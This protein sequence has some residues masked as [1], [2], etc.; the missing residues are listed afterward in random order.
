M[1]K[2]GW[3][4]SI[5]TLSLGVIIEIPGNIAIVGVLACILPTPDDAD[6]QAAGLRSS[7]SSSSTR[8]GCGSSLACSSRSCSRSRSK[9]RWACSRR[10]ARTPTSSSASGDSIRVS[11]RRR[12]RSRTPKRLAITILDEDQARIRAETYFAIT[13]NTAQFGVRAE[14]FFGFDAISISGDMRFDALFISLP[15]TSSSSSA[16]TSR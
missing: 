13:T 12:C 1:A 9:A 14:L 8:S 2:I 7:A 4:A 11:S 10:S 6:P 16:A 5:I 15:S 3:G